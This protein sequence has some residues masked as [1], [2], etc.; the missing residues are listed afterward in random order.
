MDNITS[1]LKDLYNRTPRR[2]NDENIK[3][4]NCIVTEYEDVLIAIEAINPYYE[5][6]IPSFF[7][8]LEE[9]KLMIKKSNDKKISKKSKDDYF[10]EAAGNLKDSIEKMIVVYGDGKLG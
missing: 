4:I 9:I 7:D 10:D 8:K 3:E 5:K 2:H 1:T 6:Q